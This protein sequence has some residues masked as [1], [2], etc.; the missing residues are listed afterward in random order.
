[1]PQCRCFLFLILFF[2]AYCR[3]YNLGMISLIYLQ[4]LIHHLAL[5]LC[6]IL[7]IALPK[8][9]TF[10]LRRLVV[11]PKTHLILSPHWAFVVL[12]H[13]GAFGVSAHDGVLSWHCVSAGAIHGAGTLMLYFMLM[14]RGL[15]FYLLELA[16]LA[17]VLEALVDY[18]TLL[19]PLEKEEKVFET[20]LQMHIG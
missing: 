16:H 12:C 19:G 8:R 4:Y 9:Y 1:M 5:P 20:T 10:L 11:S 3:F 6:L 14:V 18:F 17:H 15:L 13:H 7:S 2:F